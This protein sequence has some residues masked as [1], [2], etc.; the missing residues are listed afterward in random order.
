MPLPRDEG[1]DPDVL[2]H[3]LLIIFRLFL[4]FILLHALYLLLSPLILWL[5]RLMHG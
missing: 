3:I 1:H 2:G 4:F 5:Y